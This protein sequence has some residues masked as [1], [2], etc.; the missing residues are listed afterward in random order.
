[1]EAK[2]AIKQRRINNLSDG[3]S[4]AI[5]AF[6]TC[7]AYNSLSGSYAK[8]CLR[9]LYRRM[10]IEDLRLSGDLHDIFMY[11][12][13]C[14]DDLYTVGAHLSAKKRA[15]YGRELLKRVSEELDERLAFYSS[16]DILLNGAYV[17]H[18]DWTKRRR[19]VA[20][21]G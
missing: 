15:A 9:K 5:S 14:L 21:R 11:S 12:Q 19:K 8:L 20:L 6:A 10:S 4:E 2:T 16:D 17:T 7:G 3:I 1:M 13:D 18:D